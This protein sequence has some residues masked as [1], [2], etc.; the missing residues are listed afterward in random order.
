M[1]SKILKVPRPLTSAEY[2][3]TSKETFTCDCAARLYISCGLTF[4]IKFN[5]EDASVKSP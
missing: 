3:G 1:D 5:M 2:S 4:L